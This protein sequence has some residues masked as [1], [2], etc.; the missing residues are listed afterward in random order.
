M[1]VTTLFR[2]SRSRSRSTSRL[3]KR[4]RSSASPANGKRD[5]DRRNS[6]YR[7]RESGGGS[8]RSQNRLIFLVGYH[9]GIK[10]EYNLLGLGS[11]ICF[12]GCVVL[13]NF[14]LTRF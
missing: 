9:F 12:I 8:R 10:I 4:R 13:R 2:R 1:I 5:F 7:R 11:C 6:D 3:R 14:S